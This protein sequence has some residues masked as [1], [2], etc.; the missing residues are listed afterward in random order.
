[1]N[2]GH[3]KNESNRLKYFFKNYFL[4]SSTSA[5]P[6][7]RWGSLYLINIF[8]NLHFTTSRNSKHYCCW[9]TN[10][11]DIYLYPSGLDIEILDSVCSF[12]VGSGDDLS[13][14]QE[15]CSRGEDGGGEPH[16]AGAGDR[17]GADTRSGAGHRTGDW[18]HGGRR[19]PPPSGARPART[20][21]SK[22]AKGHEVG[23]V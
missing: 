23:W 2:S 1:M 14:S 8:S 21:V 13:Q 4:S 22:C 15:D 17:L 10:Y 5:T 16:G 9:E 12:L 6:D 18:G 7:L 11:R 3:G 20:L 19:H